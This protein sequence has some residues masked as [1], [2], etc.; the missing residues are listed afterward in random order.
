MVGGIKNHETL[1]LIYSLIAHG[2]RGEWWFLKKKPKTKNSCMLDSY[3]KALKKRKNAYM[4]LQIYA[5]KV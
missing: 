4:E 2:S 1:H 5:Q 3:L